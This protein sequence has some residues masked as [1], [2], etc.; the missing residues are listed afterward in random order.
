MFTLSIPIGLVHAKNNNRI[1]AAQKS[2]KKGDIDGSILLAREIL[3]NPDISKK[4]RLQLLQLIAK[5]EY[6]LASAGQ[7]K[8]INPAI[9]ALKIL[10]NEFAGQVN[11]PDIRWKILWL[12]WKN[13]NIDNTQTAIN[14]LLRH[15]PQTV[16][17]GRALLIRAR[18]FISNRQFRKARQALLQFGLNGSM[19]SH[20]EAQGFAWLAVVNKAEGHFRSASKQMNRAF[21]RIS[22]TIT[23]NSL[24]YSTYIQLLALDGKQNKALHHIAIYLTRFV[25]TPETSSIQLL[26]G[27]ILAHQRQWDK[28][29]GFYDMLAEQEAETSI[30]KKA[31][32]RKLMMR[33]HGIA[34][35]EKL[36]AALLALRRIADQNQ[37]TD[38]EAEAHLYLAELTARTVNSHP[39]RG[40][41]ALT[42][43]S[44]AMLSGDSALKAKA[45]KQGGEMFSSH[46]ASILQDEQ[47]LQAIVLWKRFPQ[48]R[49]R[50][51][52]IDNISFNISH[53]YRMLTDYAHA[54][55]I[56]DRLEKTA[57]NSI[58]GQ[59]VMLEKAH[60]WMD[61]EDVDGVNKIMSWL[62]LHEN[63]LYRPEMLLIATQMQLTMNHAAAASQTI[64]NVNADDLTTESRAD[65]WRARAHISEKLGRWHAAAAAWGKLAGISKKKEPRWLAGWYQANALF[66]AEEYARA[67]EI[68]L[69]IPES[70]RPMAW[71]YQLAICEIK[72][73]QQAQGIKH[74]TDITSKPEMGM[75]AHM[76]R[77]TLAKQNAEN[78]L[79]SR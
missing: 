35:A 12:S 52:K 57:M 33:N 73:G 65:F 14:G 6:S 23:S 37:L 3:K 71:S 9:N 28:A 51:Q 34:D 26:H 77:L 42:Y 24:L 55:E 58:W 41:A 49:P 22:D 40:N 69:K 74:L 8:K 19:D 43:Y 46:L 45:K 39:E 53:A 2:L 27:D 31:F 68:Y 7:F 11:G 4:N 48:F 25:T 44:M 21:A 59:K 47:W 13:G 78:L 18:I 56:L 66:K 32:I 36:E 64:K 5:G 16:Q 29:A 60:V 63:T 17:A 79:T 10:L 75:Y 38:I 67:M 61:R 62:S 30:G 76:A 15:H 72:T 50:A 54:E 20:A 70:M 1:I